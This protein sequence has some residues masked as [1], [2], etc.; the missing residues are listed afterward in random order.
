M[1][2]AIPRHTVEE[3]FERELASEYRHE[4]ISGEII[5]VVGASTT[6]N[7]ILENLYRLLFVSFLPDVFRV[8]SDNTRLK[9][10]DSGDYMFPDAMLVKEPA[11]YED[12]SLDTL[13]NPIIVFEVLS[14]STERRDRGEKANSYKQ[15][16]SLAHY[17][18]ISQ[19]QAS[20]ECFTRRS[21]DDWAH[22]QIDGINNEM[23]FSELG[24]KL[25]LAELYRSVNFP[26]GTNDR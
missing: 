12:N 15:V 23:E 18:L 10:A 8:C 25:K 7:K 16:D 22:R 2:I 11:Q 17:V 14:P 20:V 26:S 6:H 5:Q 3:Y 1:S 21:H 4:Y 19:N 13:L 9:P 24:W